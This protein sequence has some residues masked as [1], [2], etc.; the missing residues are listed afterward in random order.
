MVLPLHRR[1]LTF[2]APR[3]QLW[4]VWQRLLAART[5]FTFSAATFASALATFGSA[6]ASVSPLSQ[7]LR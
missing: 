6:L 5:S 4:V 7:L 1:W 2:V 3:V